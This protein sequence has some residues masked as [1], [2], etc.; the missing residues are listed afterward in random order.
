MCEAGSFFPFPLTCDVETTFRWY[1]LPV[2]EV[3]EF[4]KPITLDKDKQT[5]STIK[6]IQA[7]LV[8]NEYILPKFNTPDG[9]KPQG[10]AAEGVN[11]VWT[12]DI[13]KAIADYKQRYRLV[14][15]EEFI[16]HIERKVCKGV[17]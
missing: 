1:G 8:E 15:D 5:D 9:K 11:G 16:D 3:L 17:I 13:E 7:M 12:E 2:D 10:I 14:T 4:D 6:W